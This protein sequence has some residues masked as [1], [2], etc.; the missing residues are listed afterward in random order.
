MK[1]IN[2]SQRINIKKRFIALFTVAIMATA[3]LI[4]SAGF[5]EEINAEPSDVW[6]T[7]AATR[8]AG[9][10]PEILGLTGVEEGG[11]FVDVQAPLNW[12]L[13]KYHLMGTSINVNPNPYF[14]DLVNHGPNPVVINE[15]RSGAGAGPDAALAEYGTDP[16]P[17]SD[18]RVW[19][20][21][22]DIIIGTDGDNAIPSYVASVQAIRDATG[23]AYDPSFVQYGFQH[24]ADLIDTMYEL[25]FEANYQAVMTGKSLRYGDAFE[26]AQKYE[27]YIRGTQGLIL[28]G[29]E[30]DHADKKNV[31][32]ITAYDGDGNFTLQPTL[33]S[34]GTANQNRYV[35]TITNVAYNLADNYVDPQDPQPPAP[36]IDALE[37]ESLEADLVLIGGQGVDTTAIYDGL[38]EHRLYE[39][40][41]FL[42]RE[43][44]PG[45]T[46]IGAMYGVVMNS[47]ENGQNVGRILGVLYPEYLLPLQPL[48]NQWTMYYYDEFYHINPAFPVL[49]DTFKQAFNAEPGNPFEMDIPRWNA[50]IVDFQWDNQILDN[51]QLSKQVM[52][53]GIQTG[54]NWLLSQP[55]GT[56]PPELVPTPYIQ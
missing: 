5:A 53:A 29:L 42:V 10:A 21:L 41:R 22:P 46:Y 39:N 47:V 9:P 33:G 37:L 35:E 43:A 4:P 55:A 38:D 34:N 27:R 24:S 15:A 54:V 23:V 8:A 14:V 40:K 13:P 28:A 2:I 36:V 48:G 17:E 1:R 16:S 26:I 18:D 25:A 50:G 44:V 7:A 52:E 56:L 19:D 51:Y 45:L 3:I 12:A 49:R 11:Q 31:V 20:A 6:V 30:Q 32:V